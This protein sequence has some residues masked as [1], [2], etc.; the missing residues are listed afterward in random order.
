MKATFC[1]N[2]QPKSYTNNELNPNARESLGK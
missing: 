2:G 1:Y